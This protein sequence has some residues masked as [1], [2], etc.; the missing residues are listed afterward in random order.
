M[1]GVFN[2]ISDAF[3]SL[4]VM[5][6]DEFSYYGKP[7]TYPSA[8]VE[9]RRAGESTVIASG[10]TDS[11]GE[12]RFDYRLRPGVVERSNALEL[13]RAVGLDV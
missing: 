1:N 4:K 2:A 10:T 11:N 13:M 9:L 3:G 5:A 7:P 8:T 12:I 6:R